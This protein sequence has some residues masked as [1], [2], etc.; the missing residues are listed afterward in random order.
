MLKTIDK[1]YAKRRFYLIFS[2][3]MLSAAIILLFLTG[4]KTYRIY[5]LGKSI[6]GRSAALGLKYYKIEEFKNYKSKVEGAAAEKVRQLDETLFLNDLARTVNDSGSE[7]VMYRPAAKQLAGPELDIE[8]LPAE[9]TLRGSYGNIANFFGSL[10][11]S[12]NLCKIDKFALRIADE[13][14]TALNAVISLRAYPF[15]PAGG[16][17]PS[18]DAIKRDPFELQSQSFSGPV[19]ISSKPVLTG[20]ISIQG[21]GNYALIRKGG[22]SFVL[23]K[24][25]R[26]DEGIIINTI[27]TKSVIISTDKG[28]RAVRINE[29]F[30]AGR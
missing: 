15:N 9:V 28:E 25:D 12:S 26:V 17:L 16:A 20:I 14:A 30:E 1:L 19:I 2:A 11:R 6:E 13:K 4:T 27:Y 21:S 22:K 24:G 7:L 8:E 10:A 18:S 23:K 5:K 29:Q 3:L